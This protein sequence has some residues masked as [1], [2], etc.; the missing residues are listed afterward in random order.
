[1]GFWEGLKEA[2]RDGYRSG[3]DGVSPASLR[4]SAPL[5][6]IAKLIPR[7]HITVGV[8]ILLFGIFGYQISFTMAWV[9]LGLGLL[10]FT[11]NARIPRLLRVF[12]YAWVMFP[13][14][15]WFDKFDRFLFHQPH[16]Q[17]GLRSNETLT[18][19]MVFEWCFFVIAFVSLILVGKHRPR[20]IA[21][22]GGQRADGG[23]SSAQDTKS[24]WSNIP[25]R[26]FADVGGMEEEKQRIAAI[27]NNRLHPEQFAKHGVV[28]NGILLYGP[29]GTGKTF[30][31]EATA[32]EFKINYYYVRPNEFVEGPIGNS[33]ANIRDAF[34]RAYDNRPI[35]L[36]IDE[37][38]AI[39]TQR[40]Q[41]GRG[42]DRG[43]AARAYNAIVTELMQCIDRYRTTSGF[44]IMAATNFYEMLDE[45]LV[46]E[47]RFDE[48]IRID[49]PDE[50]AR[51]EI[52][53]AQL[54][55]RPWKSF[56]LDTFAKRTPGWSAAKLANLVNKAAGFAAAENRPIGRQDLE[57]AFERTGGVDR[58]NFKPVN[59]NDLVLLA[60]VERDLRDLI[61]LMN[62]SHANQPRMLVPTGLLLM[63]APG[64]GK[65][66]IA[67]L[68]A[69]QTRRSFYSIAPADVPS[70]EKLERAFARAR[71]NSPS[72]LFF[73]EI[74]GILPAPNGK[75]F[76]SQYQEQIVDQ[77]L[78]LMSQ[79]DPGNQVFLVGT[80][81][82]IEDID[83]RILRGGRFTEKIELEAPD[84][85][86]YLRLI[87]KYLDGVPLVQGFRAEDLVHGLR[88]ISP[89]D[90]E[91][92]VN[93]A[94]RM[95]FGR[96]AEQSTMEIP[97]LTRE[98]FDK[99]LKRN[100]PIGAL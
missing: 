75:Y 73:D 16:A 77:A 94:K 11:W 41:I 96:R 70:T 92:V 26:T 78:M 53:T 83:P 98:D 40:Q 39:G 99:A 65:T 47:M 35:L 8:F 86:G 22:V 80:T 69:T 7:E 76:M 88:G 66:T 48:R 81:N 23:R 95:A 9:S 85:E 17:V 24:V 60:T 30:I 91:A 44:I 79:L 32:G 64:T 15:A 38:D 57:G 49:L 25:S 31:A 3:E 62:A 55:K 27:V 67:H 20:K 34:S 13:V 63:G 50:A 54:A 74:D 6:R 43:G 56:E 28:Q 72:I 68:I 84:D 87:G 97:P 93:T 36:F 1:M 18:T 21:Q 29:R 19:E 90:L 71:E 89:A 58:P 2:F 59:W 4:L 82:H 61:S 12:F 45:A 33:E 42:D 52:L 100:R 51:I 14:I 10:L 46:R 5:N 37:L